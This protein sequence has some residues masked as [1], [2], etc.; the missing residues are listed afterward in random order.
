MSN[1]DGSQRSHVRRYDSDEQEAYLN[2]WRT[3]DRLKA[4]EEEVFTTVGL[5]AQQ[6][7][8]LRLLQI[9]HPATL[10]V[11]GIG[12]KLISRA[13]DMT[14]LLD[15]LE[16]RGWITRT[17]R[18]DNRRVVDVA[19]TSAGLQL[20]KQLADRVI[21]CH[22]RQL[23][24]LSSSE[25]RTLSD[26]LIKARSPHEEIGGPWDPEQLVRSRPLNSKQALET[27][28]E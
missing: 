17:R 3:Y 24:H 22:E 16:Q 6:Y 11:Q 18:E 8:A 12:A 2:L 5:S 15:R 1:R 28:R 25:L 21:A 14:R 27:N 20:L 26:L 13:P 10:T 9:V 23:G 4:Y 19:I 7:N